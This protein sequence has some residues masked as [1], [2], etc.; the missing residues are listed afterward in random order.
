M[1]RGRRTGRRSPLAAA[2]ASGLASNRAAPTP[3]A[4]WASEPWR[5]ARAALCPPGSS[6][7]VAP[8][9]GTVTVSTPVSWNQPKARTSVAS[10]D[11]S[12][13]SSF[14]VMVPVAPEYGP[15]HQ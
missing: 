5:T 3:R 9:Y 13:P 10:R 14:S 11:N 8:A 15:C 6:R 1:W 7:A 12:A 4:A 2:E